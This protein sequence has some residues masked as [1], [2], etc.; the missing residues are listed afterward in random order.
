VLQ[1]GCRCIELDCWDGSK[2]IPVGNPGDEPIITHG[3]TF[4]TR[5]FFRDVIEA[6]NNSAFAAPANNPFPVILSIEMHCSGRFQDRMWEICTEIFGD[7][8]LLLTDEAMSLRCRGQA[9]RPAGGSVAREAWRR[10]WGRGRVR[11]ERGSV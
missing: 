10:G 2:D 11:E 5:I 9:G 6:I 7:R 8:L 4:C 1:R 3:N